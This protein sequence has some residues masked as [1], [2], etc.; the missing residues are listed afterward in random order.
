MVNMISLLEEGQREVIN[1]ILSSPLIPLQRGKPN[2]LPSLRD[3]E[4]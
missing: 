1:L 2:I 3:N 4:R